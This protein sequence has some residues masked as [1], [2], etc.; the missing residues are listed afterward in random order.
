MFEHRL[1]SATNDLWPITAIGYRRWIDVRVDRTKQHHHWRSHMPRRQCTLAWTFTSSRALGLPVGFVVHPNGMNVADASQS[2]VSCELHVWRTGGWTFRQQKAGTPTSSPGCFTCEPLELLAAANHRVPHKIAPA[3]TE[4]NARLEDS[5]KTLERHRSD[6]FE[7][8]KFPEFL[9]IVL[10]Q[11]KN[12]P[13]DTTNEQMHSF[14]DAFKAWQK[15]FATF[16]YFSDLWTIIGW[17]HFD[18]LNWI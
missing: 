7:P 2:E 18:S 14:E 17:I 16:R 9:W 13:E 4:S 5:W 12:C 15:R 1:W 10:S 6:F 11:L 3:Q 8:S